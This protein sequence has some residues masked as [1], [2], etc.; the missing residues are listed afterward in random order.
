LGRAGV[1]LP[2]NQ[3]SIIGKDARIADIIF[4]SGISLI[5]DDSASCCGWSDPFNV[6]SKAA[7]G[8]SDSRQAL[9]AQ[10]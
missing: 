10:A 5:E 1:D 7:S 4:S 6:A 2:A 9:K 8:Y 3:H